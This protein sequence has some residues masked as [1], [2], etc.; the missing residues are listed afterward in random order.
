MEQANRWKDGCDALLIH[1][2]PKRKVLCKMNPGITRQR[3][4]LLLCCFCFLLLFQEPVATAAQPEFQVGQKLQVQGLNLPEDTYIIAVQQADVTGDAANDTV[5]LAGQPLRD[6]PAF[7]NL[8]TVV[9]RDGKT[10]KF[11]TLPQNRIKDYLRGYEPKMFLGDVTGDKLKDVMVSVA[12]GGSGGTSNYLVA[13]WKNN[14]PDVIFG[15]KENQGLRIKGK[16]LNGFKAEMHSETL[17]KTFIVDLSGYRKQLI[18]GKIY[19]PNGTY[20]FQTADR[21]RDS[22]HDIFSDPF[23]SLVPVDPDNDGVYSLIGEQNV[24]G[25]IHIYTLTTVESTWMYQNGKWNIPDA[26]YTLTYPILND[27]E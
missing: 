12:T 27:N 11:S 24:W 26:H 4:C 9:V 19:D 8:V 22:R 25:P 14:K 20:I 13:A 3:A 23:Y 21:G 2:K 10:G 1:G 15:E 16:F 17:N 5:F 7:Y 6:N 18:Q